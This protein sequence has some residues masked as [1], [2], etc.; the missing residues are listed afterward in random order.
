MAD[1]SGTAN[2][3]VTVMDNGG[4]AGGGVNTFQRTFTVTVNPV[5][6]VPT[7]APL[8]N[9]VYLENSGTQ[10]IP[11]NGLSAGLGD[12]LPGVTAQFLNVFATSSNT[13]LI[14]NPSVTYSNPSSS[15]TL[16]LH[17]GSERQRHGDDHR[18]RAGQRRHRQRRPEHDDR[19]LHGDGHAGQPA[20]HDQL[21]SQPHRRADS[22]GQQ[23]IALSGIGTGPGDAA[24]AHGHAQRQPTVSAI[25]VTNGGSGYTS[26]PVVTISA[27]TGTGPVQAM[28]TATVV[29]GVVTGITITNAGSGLPR[30]PDLTI[31]LG[32]TVTITAVSNNPALV[33]NTGTGRC[34]Q[35]HPRQHHRHAHV[36]PRRRARPARP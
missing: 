1:T 30:G 21:R 24:T 9:V 2:I 4:T 33:A 23:T 15:G 34:G 17:T 36:T 26:V 20:A 14:P 22:A 12:S 3:T 35:L 7:I 8:N 27:P 32:Q 19:D 5:N 25:K 6:Q 13:A 28:A 18:R 31:S 29:G 11:L 16:S 10:T